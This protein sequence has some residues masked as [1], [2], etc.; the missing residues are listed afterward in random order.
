MGCVHPHP[1]IQNTPIGKAIK[2]LQGNED[3][4]QFCWKIEVKD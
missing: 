4:A 1:N 3:I 2:N